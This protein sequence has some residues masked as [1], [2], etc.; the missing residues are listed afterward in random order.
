MT[1]ISENKTGY[2]NTSA[3]IQQMLVADGTY[4]SMVTYETHAGSET[5]NITVTVE[6]DTV[7]AA[8]VTDNSPNSPISAQKIQ[9]LNNAIQTTSLVLGQPI[10]TISIP[11]NVAGSSLTT[12]AF[13]GFINNLLTNGTQGAS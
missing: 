3:T 10:N 9:A 4:S 1:T 8:S 5:V 6:N 12:A 2:D 7:T 13:A 11:H